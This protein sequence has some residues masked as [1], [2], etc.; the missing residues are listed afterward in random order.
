MNILEK[1]FCFFHNLL[2]Q[3]TKSS[4]PFANQCAMKDQYERNDIGYYSTLYEKLNPRLKIAQDEELWGYD[5]EDYENKSYVVVGGTSDFPY[6]SY[7]MRGNFDSY[8]VLRIDYDDI[9]NENFDTTM[10]EKVKII[11]KVLYCYLFHTLTEQGSRMEKQLH[12][13]LF[14]N[15]K[16]PVIVNGSIEEILLLKENEFTLLIENKFN[17]K[18][19]H[20]DMNEES[21]IE[22]FVSRKLA[23]Q[24]VNKKQLKAIQSTILSLSISYRIPDEF[25]PEN[26]DTYR[27]EFETNDFLLDGDVFDYSVRVFFHKRNIDLT[28]KSIDRFLWCFPSVEEL[29]TIAAFTTTME[30]PFDTPPPISL[31]LFKPSNYGTNLLNTGEV[32]FPY[33]VTNN[34]S[35]ATVNF[36]KVDFAAKVALL[37][38]AKSEQ[39]KEYTLNRIVN[40]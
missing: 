10:K 21:L 13:Q 31:A 34:D 32:T 18:L 33:V 16:I 26:N 19:P 9:Y 36:H 3:N 17:A 6:I 30:Y 38:A 23:E 8:T 2:F 27:R 24:L 1:T 7:I 15:G 20:E 22:H 14:I 39:Y 29:Q 4:L 5:Y 40:L 37:L 25:N 35:T 28:L 11:V 12:L